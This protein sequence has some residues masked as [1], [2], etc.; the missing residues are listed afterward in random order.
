MKAKSSKKK[1]NN[2]H[3]KTNKRLY[4][5]GLHQKSQFFT[6]TLKKFTKDYIK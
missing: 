2:F 6:K 3:I 5:L 4:F 1:T